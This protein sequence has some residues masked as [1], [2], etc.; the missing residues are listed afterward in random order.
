MVPSVLRELFYFLSSVS[1]VT[2]NL[3][4]TVNGFILAVAFYFRFALIVCS[5]VFLLS[6]NLALFFKGLNKDGS[7]TNVFEF[8]S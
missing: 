7:V 4:C 5:A 6:S 2:G 8:H 3:V 1:N